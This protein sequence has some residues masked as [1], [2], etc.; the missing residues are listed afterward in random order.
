[1]RGKKKRIEKFHRYTQQ[2]RALRANAVLVL[3]SRFSAVSDMCRAGAEELRQA[4][5]MA[6]MMQMET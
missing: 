3:Q 4:D 1:M 2:V 5:N 6:L